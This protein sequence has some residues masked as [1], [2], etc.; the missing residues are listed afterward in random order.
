[1]TLPENGYVLEPATD[2]ERIRG[3]YRLLEQI[4]RGGQATTHRALDERTGETVALKELRLRYVEDWKSVELFE[5]EA[6][7]LQRLEHPAVP[8]VVDAFSVEPEAASGDDMR[9]FM[10]QEFVDGPSLEQLL[11]AGERW[12]TDDL[13]DFLRQM[14][15]IL[16][17]LQSLEPPVLHR[18]LK[19]SNI[20]RRA[21]D[22]RYVLIDFGAV[23][24]VTA[25]TQG[26]STFIGTA[27]YIAPEQLVGRACP[28]SDLYAL[29]ATAL[30]LHSGTTPQDM[31]MR[32]MRYEVGEVLDPQAPPRLRR[33]LEGMVA[34]AL[35][36]RYGRAELA[37][38]ALDGAADSGALVAT[39]RAL[40]PFSSRTEISLALLFAAPF[41]AFVVF[42]ISIALCLAL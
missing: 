28:A 6:Q 25:T 23:Q 11:S 18:D 20:L 31:P 32:R 36:D 27:G 42:T 13:E 38:Q 19:P 41:V 4:G 24:L 8:R 12:G 14:L 26:G 21:G 17:Y 2:G 5:R 30:Q 29:G 9:F 16:A 35:E 33:T 37:L 3:R 1:M 39:A 34:P 40:S 15:E 22:G 10:V 7:A